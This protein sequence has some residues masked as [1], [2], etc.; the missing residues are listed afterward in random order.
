ML[1]QL[2]LQ[3][4]AGLDEEA[5]IDGLVG[6]LRVL[7]LGRRALEPPGNL[8]GRP[9][10][11]QLPC[12]AVRE[13]PVLYQFTDLRAA[14]PLP[15]RFI[16]PVGTVSEPA[17]VAPN[18]ATD[19]GRCATQ[20]SGNRTDRAAGHHIAGDLLPFRQRQRP[21]RS[22]PRPYATGLFQNTLHRGMV[23][24]KEPRDRAQGLAF[25]PAVPH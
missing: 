2:F 22:S 16:G 21:S 5:S 13:L 25:L 11:L 15:G 14:C 20:R 24:V 23:A 17:A 1:Q 4:P 12:H 9:E 8:L 10:F 3:G 6:H 18:L 7:L 19:R